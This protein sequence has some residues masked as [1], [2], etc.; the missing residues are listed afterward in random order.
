M[1]FQIRLFEEIYYHNFLNILSRQEMHIG[2]LMCVI[3]KSKYET[4]KCSYQTMTIA[5]K[6]SISFLLNNKDPV[7]RQKI[8]SNVKISRDFSREKMKENLGINERTIEINLLFFV[9]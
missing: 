4:Y 8:N 7:I 9:G 2:I 6:E 3:D 1:G 5:L